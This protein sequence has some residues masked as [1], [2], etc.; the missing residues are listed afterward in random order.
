[1]DIPILI[2]IPIW[3]QILIRY[4]THIPR[5]GSEFVSGNAKYN[6][7]KVSPGGTYWGTSARDRAGTS[8]SVWA[9]ASDSN[10]D[11]H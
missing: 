9:R 2:Q 4:C 6:V 1:M 11:R 5:S 7:V 10:S 8:A 3:T